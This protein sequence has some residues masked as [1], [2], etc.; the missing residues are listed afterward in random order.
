MTDRYNSFIVVMAEDRRDDDA[1]ATIAA[2][3]QIK[4]V[5]SVKP[6]LGGDY[7]AQA[8][9]HRVK[10]EIADDLIIMATKLLKS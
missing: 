1:K 3:K 8:E 10:T 9:A 6:V 2:L 4:G 5:I 7:S